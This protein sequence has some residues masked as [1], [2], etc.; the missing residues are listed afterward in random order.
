MGDHGTA[1]AHLPAPVS[2]QPIDHR[3]ALRRRRSS[4]LIAGLFHSMHN[5]MV[6]S[7]GLVAVVALHSSKG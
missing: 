5:A 7:S 3:L 1:A 2:R 4:V 6:N